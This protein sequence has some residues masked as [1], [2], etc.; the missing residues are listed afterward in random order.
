MREY[1]YLRFDAY[2]A[3][4]LHDFIKTIEVDTKNETISTIRKQLKEA[5]SLE[6]NE[7]VF[8]VYNNKE[9]AQQEFRRWLMPDE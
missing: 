7:N 4:D 5:R 1:C 9:V 6:R 3:N 8:L 2:N